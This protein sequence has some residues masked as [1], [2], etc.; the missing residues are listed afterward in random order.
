MI[1]TIAGIFLVVVAIIIFRFVT[2]ATLTLVTNDAS[3][4]LFIHE[5]KPINQD[6]DISHNEKQVVVH[7][8]A[9]NYTITA[10]NN[11]T[12]SIQVIDVGVGESK[13]VTLNL[14]AASTVA[15]DT[16]PV[17]SLGAG[18]FAASSNRIT[19]VD[20]NSADTPMYTV[21][22]SNHV[23]LLD[24][25]HRYNL[26]KWMGP[27]FA[28]GLFNSGSTYGLVKLDGQTVS[29][30]ALPFTDTSSI[31]MAIAPDKSWYVS[32]G[33]TVYSANGDGSFTV[34]YKTDSNVSVSSAS[35]DAVMLTQTDANSPREGNLIV[36]HRDGTK[37]QIEGEL[38]SSAWS[39]SGKKVITSGDSAQIFDDK[40]N[41]VH[42][43]PHGNVISPV[44]LDEN[45]LIYS[46]GSNVWR[47][48]LNTGKAYVIISISPV[49]G[50][51]SM[52]QPD[53]THDFIYTAIYKGNTSTQ[54]YI[55]NRVS[56]GSKQVIDSSIARSLSVVLPDT[57]NGCSINYMNFTALAIVTKQTAGGA[58]CVAET[59]NVTVGSK[60]LSAGEAA[61]LSYQQL[62]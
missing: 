47:Y 27:E 59:K 8:D 56:L 4:Q 41:I 17:T 3:N 15:L 10:K 54:N 44:W 33:H 26:V 13:T 5:N 18:T 32:N 12:S 28:I 2:S 61:N 22:Q 53:D 52:V 25:K 51:F 29:T 34:V 21:D 24:N 7:L 38:Y 42:E 14:A 16:V 23:S 43:L 1:Y 49:V 62:P 31:S 60:V 46:L 40:L 9:G 19:F 11:Y 30:V 6:I 37:Y 20:M 39:P 48:D 55:L 35:N 57:S 45:S 36:I 50:S 58:N